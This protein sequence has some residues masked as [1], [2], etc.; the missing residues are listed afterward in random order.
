VWIFRPFRDEANIIPTAPGHCLA[1][2][3]HSRTASG[4]TARLSAL[5]STYISLYTPHLSS[6]SCEFQQNQFH[7]WQLLMNWQARV[8]VDWRQ[9]KYVNF[10]RSPSAEHTD[11]LIDTITHFM[12]FICRYLY[13]I[14][15]GIL[16]LL[17]MAIASSLDV[18][19]LL[20]LYSCSI[21]IVYCNIKNL[22]G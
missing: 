17:R 9:M 5:Y 6:N 18:V 21:D 19:L 8:E 11:T 14:G 12:L 20:Q 16:V 10:S 1:S 4:Y 22:A 3:T 2:T 7:Y 15:I 13:C